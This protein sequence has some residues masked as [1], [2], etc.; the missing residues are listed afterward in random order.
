MEQ[1]PSLEA[2][3]CS[4]IHGVSRILWNVFEDLRV[5]GRIIIK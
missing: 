3:S 4:T 2:D 5:E 1:S